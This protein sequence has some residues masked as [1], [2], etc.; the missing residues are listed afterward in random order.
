MLEVATDHDLRGALIKA[1]I[2]SLCGSAL[3]AI[4]SILAEASIDETTTRVLMTTGAPS[5][6]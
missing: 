2:A 6:R 3:I 1:F 4:V 5:P